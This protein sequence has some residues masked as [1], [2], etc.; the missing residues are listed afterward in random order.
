MRNYTYF[1]LSF[2]LIP[3][4]CTSQIPSA[5]M[6]LW[7]K[8][9]DG[10]YIDALV[11]PATDSTLVQIW[12]DRSGNGN[13]F[14]Q[15]DSNKRPAMIESVLCGQPV[16]RFNSGRRTF[17]YSNMRLSGIKTVFVVFIKPSILGEAGELISLKGNSNEFSEVVVTD[18][19]GYDPVTFIFDLPSTSAGSFFRNSVGIGASFSGLGNLVVVSYNGG[20]ISDPANYSAYYDNVSLPVSGNGLLGRYSGDS[21]TIGARAPFQ[22][23]NFLNGDIAEMIVYDRILS[24][25]EIN[26]VSDYLIYKYG[27]LGNCVLPVKLNYFDAKLS[28]TKVRVSWEMGNETGIEKYQIQR[29]IDGQSWHSLDFVSASHNYRQYL[30]CDENPYS[31]RSYYRLA[32]FN[33]K[34]IIGYSAVKSVNSLFSSARTQIFNLFPNPAADFFFVESS[35]PESLIVTIV[36]GNGQLVKKQNVLPGQKINISDL[37][38][39][40][41]VINIRGKQTEANHKLIIR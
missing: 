37:S 25:A 18:F 28:G 33:N 1:F 30:F 26:D 39:G 20:V 36:A 11:T 32:I 17:L 31:G 3:F 35:Y 24:L 27:L 40:V 19:P 7:L 41:Y 10:A 21:T 8:A 29:S 6:K 14:I 2:F 22:N 23:I 5:G 4:F 9:D 13:H 38:R 34:E 12:A 16:L 15:L